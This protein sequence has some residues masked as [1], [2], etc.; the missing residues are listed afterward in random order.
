MKAT[1]RA[2]Q[3]MGCNVVT[4][5]MGSPIWKAWYSFPPTTEEMIEAGFEKILELWT[6]IF[7]EFDALRRQ[8]RPRGPPD[9]D[10]LRPLHRPS[11]CSTSSTAGRPSGFNF[12]PSHLVWQGI[13]PHLFIRD[14]A[15]RDLPR[16]HEG[17]RP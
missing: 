11:A 12:D 2:A 17:R 3:A 5:F 14:F 6:P 10:R 9:R 15:D 7:D 1:A 4:G 13:E 16:P 8:V